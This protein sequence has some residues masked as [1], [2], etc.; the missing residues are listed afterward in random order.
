MGSDE[1]LKEISEQLKEGIKPP[2]V[3]ARDFI[4]W[5]AAQRRSSW[6]VEYI[7]G[8]L[9]KYKLITIPDF[10]YV[11][12]DSKIT[13]KRAPQKSAQPESSELVQDI[14]DD[15]TYR[16]GKLASANNPPVS[17]KPDDKVITASTLMITNDYS[18]LPVM[19]S[20]REVKGIIIWKS[21]AS[22]LA[23]G[24]ESEYV[25]DCMEP[26]KELSYDAYIFSAIE[27]IISNE[28]VLIR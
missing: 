5:F 20:D 11:Y 26:H 16:I 25:R 17:V 23:L 9:K 1:K 10:E 19:T 2:Y 18:Q 3:T 21:I 27:D 8:L 28:Y 14:K 15:P 22:N 24:T 12:I 6:N 13:F 7:R 4:W